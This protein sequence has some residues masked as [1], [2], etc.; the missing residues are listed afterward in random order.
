MKSILPTGWLLPAIA[1]LSGWG[2]VHLHN[3]AENRQA[4]AAVQHFQ[5]FQTNSG[6]VYGVMLANHQKAEL[7]MSARLT[8]AAEQDFQARA[9]GVTSKTWGRIRDELARAMET[10]PGASNTVASEFTRFVGQITGARAAL[11]SDTEALTALQAERAAAENAALQWQAR[12]IFFRGALETFA[13]AS[14]NHLPDR[15]SL[16]QARRDIERRPVGDST[17]GEILKGDLANLEKLRVAGLVNAYTLDLFDPTAAPGLKVQMLGLGEDLARAGIARAK[18]TIEYLNSVTNLFSNWNQAL[19][20]Q[21]KH[22]QLAQNPLGSLLTA[23]P[24]LVE[25]RVLAT[26]ERFR[27]Q[28]CLTQLEVCGQALE[29]YAVALS[30]DRAAIDELSRKPASLEH[31][32]SIRISRINASER[33]ALLARGLQSLERYHSGGITPEQIANLLQAAEAAGIG[34]IGARLH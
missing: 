15:R 13:S 10:L 22:L 4:T 28:N 34:V 31:E 25:T 20:L 1:V 3:A 17:V 12:W 19:G 29:W 11:K 21:A 7:A 16:D 5:Q 8:A 2:C 27:S 18:T 24:G 33:E 14:G 6:G 26:L 32:H 30:F 23:D 9:G